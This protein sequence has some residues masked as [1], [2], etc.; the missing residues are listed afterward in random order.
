MKQYNTSSEDIMIC[1]YLYFYNKNVL[2]GSGSFDIGD[3]L[4]Q[5]FPIDIENVYGSVII[6]AN[7]RTNEKI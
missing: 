2:L 5:F 1:D 7:W 4:Y 3:Y 6:M